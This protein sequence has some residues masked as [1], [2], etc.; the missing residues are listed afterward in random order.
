MMLFWFDIYF[1]TDGHDLRLLLLFESV[2]TLSMGT[3][4]YK[5]N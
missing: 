1:P 2:K 4:K 3:G 5:G